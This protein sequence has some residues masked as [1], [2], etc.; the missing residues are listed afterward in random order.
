MFSMTMLFTPLNKLGVRLEM[1]VEVISGHPLARGLGF[2][3]IVEDKETGK[4]FKVYGAS[5]DFEHCEC[6]ARIEDI[7]EA[8]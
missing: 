8:I 6:D 2:R 5:C 4:R 1:D 7:Q 3:G